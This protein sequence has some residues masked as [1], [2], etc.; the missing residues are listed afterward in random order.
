MVDGGKPTTVGLR[1]LDAANTIAEAGADN[2][3]SAEVVRAV[4]GV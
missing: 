4:Y 1:G 3:L 2:Q